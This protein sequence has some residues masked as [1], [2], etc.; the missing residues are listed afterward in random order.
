[1]KNLGYIQICFLVCALK[2]KLRREFHGGRLWQ[3]NFLGDTSLF[4][5]TQIWDK[6][7]F[8][9]CICMYVCPEKVAN[10]SLFKRNYFNLTNGSAC[11]KNNMYHILT[12][13]TLT[14]DKIYSLSDFIW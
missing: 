4:L 10:F 1:M 2:Q 8:Y 9:V 7:K 6:I 13:D 3:N 5:A 14:Y 12:T 11:A